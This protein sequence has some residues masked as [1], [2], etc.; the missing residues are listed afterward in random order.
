MPI[1]G[2]MISAI[3]DIQNI[4]KEVNATV[5]KVLPFLHSINPAITWASPP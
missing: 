3:K 4:P 1:L 2:K 5:P